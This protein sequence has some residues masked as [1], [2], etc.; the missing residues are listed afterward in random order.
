MNDRAARIFAIVAL[1]LFSE[2]FFSLFVGPADS[3]DDVSFLRYVWPP[4]YLGTIIAVAAMPRE[5]LLAARRNWLLLVVVALCVA[6]TLW[7]VEPATSLRR[8][9]ALAFTSLFG[10]WLAVRFDARERLRLLAVAFA[11]LAVGRVVMALLL[12][13]Y[14]LMQ[15][16]PS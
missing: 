1:L 5:I 6:S 9:V 4:I 10:L 2:G 11:I 3:A 16:V 13:Q 12:P 15:E 8:A 14:G 7:S